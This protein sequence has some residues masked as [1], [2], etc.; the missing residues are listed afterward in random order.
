MDFPKK[1]ILRGIEVEIGSWDELDEIVNRYGSAEVVR[2]ISSPGSGASARNAALAPA[3]RTL[4]AMFVENGPRGVL[5]KDLGPHLGTVGKGIK[6]AL[7][8]WARKIGLVADDSSASAFEP[9]NMGM[10]GRGYRMT[11]LYI[12]AA[13][14]M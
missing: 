1:I 13:R 9:V 4:L 10:L 14:S 5:N 11:D 2:S 8:R 3:D 12:Q 6:P 7:D